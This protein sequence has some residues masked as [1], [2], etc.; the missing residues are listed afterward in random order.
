MVKIF[1]KLFKKIN[2]IEMQNLVVT[3]TRN[4]GHFKFTGKLSQ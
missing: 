4:K 2:V 3:L 1:N